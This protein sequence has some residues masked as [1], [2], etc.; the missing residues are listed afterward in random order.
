MP[1]RLNVIHAFL[2]T[3][4]I[5]RARDPLRGPDA[6]GDWCRSAGFGCADLLDSELDR[7]RAFREALRAVAAANA[8]EGDARAAWRALEPF[9]YQSRLSIRIDGAR[10]RLVPDGQGVE[11]MIAALL[12][13]VHD[14][15]VAGTWVRLKA[16]AEHNC[17][18][19]FFDR[20]K[21]LKGTWCSMAVCGNRNK[22]RRRR[23]REKG[24]A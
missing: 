20:S 18:W 15:V 1:D 17:R 22:A 14:A 11:S 24:A 13:I 7:L 4:E 23:A 8:G 16:C 9:A 2:N 19:A 6:L 10:P 3:V 21:N 12:A 5:E